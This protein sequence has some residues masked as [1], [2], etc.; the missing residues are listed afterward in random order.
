MKY[1][2]SSKYENTLLKIKIRSFF[3]AGPVKI[4]GG[5]ATGPTWLSGEKSVIVEPWFTIIC[6][7]SAAI[8]SIENLH[9]HLI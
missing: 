2:I 8:W 7:I 3:C 1:S 6:W 9:K 5:K 4:I